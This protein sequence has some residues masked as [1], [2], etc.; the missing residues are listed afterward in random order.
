[1]S[2]GSDMD[3]ATRNL[4]FRSPMGPPGG[5]PPLLNSAK[6]KPRTAPVSPRLVSLDGGKYGVAGMGDFP[7][8]VAGQD[9]PPRLAAG[10]PPTSLRSWGEKWT[11]QP[12]DNGDYLWTSPLGG[13]GYT[14]SGND[15]P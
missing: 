9:P 6:S 2:Q 12:L 13:P 5:D 8:R 10:L 15:P 4:S 11:Y 3:L 14:T 1:V 7:T